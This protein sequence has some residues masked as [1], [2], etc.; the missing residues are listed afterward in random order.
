[1]LTDGLYGAIIGAI[2]GALITAAASLGIVRWQR[3]NDENAAAQRHQEDKKAAAK[4]QRNEVARAAHLLVAEYQSKVL[5]IANRAIAIQYQVQ[6]KDNP[7]ATKD[8]GPAANDL[9]SLSYGRDIIIRLEQCCPEQKRRMVELEDNKL[10]AVPGAYKDVS[11]L[12]E[13][14]MNLINGLTVMRN[15]LASMIRE[16]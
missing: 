11:D 1:M 3:S 8:V 13:A 15:D 10:G 14:C 5:E 12:F 9:I 4:A 6:Y 16:E 7:E 2:I